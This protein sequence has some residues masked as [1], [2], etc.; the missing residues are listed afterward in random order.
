[1]QQAGREKEKESYS[2]WTRDV[3]SQGFDTLPQQI[4]AAAEDVAPVPKQ[5]TTRSV[6]QHMCL[7]APASTLY[8]SHLLRWLSYRRAVS[9][10]ARVGTR[11]LSCALCEAEV[12]LAEGRGE[13]RDSNILNGCSR[14]FKSS[15]VRAFSI[16]PSFL[17]LL[18]F[19]LSSTHP[20]K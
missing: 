3:C 10:S 14:T 8:P 11:A 15:F 6:G 9:S 12:A 4:T 20:S 5:F 13:Q 16:T 7:H 1:M 17:T 19:L 18:V 2:F